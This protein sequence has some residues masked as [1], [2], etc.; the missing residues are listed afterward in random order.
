MRL[1]KQ[2]S[3]WSCLPTAFAMAADIPVQAMLIWIGHDGSEIVRPEEPERYCRRAFHI[4]EMIDVMF[5]NHYAVIPFEAQPIL[6][7]GRG[8]DVKVDFPIGLVDRLAMLVD[9]EVGVF[10][11]QS[12]KGNPH[13]VA[14]DGFRIYDPKGEILPISEF[15]IQTFWMCRRLP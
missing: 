9:K 14:W 3:A 12:M 13:A 4:Q 7:I 6:S 5:I 1:Q 15:N 11:G 2:P 10:T 8:E